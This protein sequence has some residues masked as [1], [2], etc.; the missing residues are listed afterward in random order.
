MRIL[1]CAF[2]AA[3]GLGFVTPPCLAGPQKLP[4]RFAGDTP[5]LEHMLSPQVPASSDLDNELAGMPEK[6][7]AE[8]LT[9][10]RVF[11]LALL[12]SRA[13][14]GQAA[15]A[16]V[17]AELTAKAKQ[18]GFDDFTQFRNAF[19]TGRPGP[20]GRYRDPSAQY[21]EVLRRLQSISSARRN[22]AIHETL[23]VLIRELIQ[24]GSSGLSQLDVDRVNALLERARQG[25]AS[26][27]G[28]Y[29]DELDQMKAALGLSPRAAVVPDRRI[30][31]AFES[32]WEDTHNWLRSPQRNLAELH[33]LVERLPVLGEVIVGA[34][35]LPG[36]IDAKSSAIDE[37]LTDA[38]DLAIRNRGARAAGDLAGDSEIQL[39]LRVRR[40]SRHLLDTR[41]EYDRE[42][43]RVNLAVRLS[44]QSFER[45]VAPASGVIGA[46]SQLLRDLLDHLAEIRK[47]EVRLVGL[48]TGFRAERLAL[49]RDLGVLPYDNWTS[50]YQD[51]SAV[52]AEARPAPGNAA[53]PGV[54]R[55]PPA[56]PPPPGVLVQPPPSP[57]PAPHPATSPPRGSG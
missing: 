42:K 47:V 7:H 40:R 49:Y 35:R 8:L 41:T 18:H 9:W 51:L 4:S 31:S 1:V 16:L 33:S 39:E 13:G 48:W 24:G 56:P 5:G 17:P 20:E 10:E 25:L 43:H 19:L 21:L 28:G 14:N 26:D 52:V 53:P 3:A 36:A 32:A 54:D 22:V 30:L 46:R 11:A 45:L 27:V 44:D 34:R 55:L 23:L 29:R 6:K 2:I 15:A 37:F 38:A 50:F 12:H 57:A